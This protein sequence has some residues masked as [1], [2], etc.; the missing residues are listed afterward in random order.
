MKMAEIKKR[1]NLK[2]KLAEKE[3]ASTEAYEIE[4]KKEMKR[5]E[6]SCAEE[7]GAEKLSI[8]QSYNAQALELNV[9]IDIGKFVKLCIK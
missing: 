7:A 2:I 4:M 9:Q 3:G 8:K 1:F 5:A 6:Q